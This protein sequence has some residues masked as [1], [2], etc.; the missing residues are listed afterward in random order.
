MGLSGVRRQIRISTFA[1]EDC[2]DDLKH[3]S[4]VT[5]LHDVARSRLWAFDRLHYW[6]GHDP[7]IRV[8]GVA[9]TR[10]RRCVGR[11]PDGR[12]EAT[13]PAAGSESRAKLGRG[14]WK[15]F[16]NEREPYAPLSVERRSLPVQL[17]N[18][19]PSGV[20]T[21]RPLGPAVAQL[22]N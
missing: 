20:R 3:E 13:A 17:A 18:D 21:N 10:V 1:F 15:I 14:G 9:L 22:R 19:R 8:L 7:P 2:R 12:A 5:D 16:A 6:P 11:G 4:I